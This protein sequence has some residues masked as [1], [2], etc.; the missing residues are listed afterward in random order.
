M[1]DQNK[2]ERLILQHSKH[3]SKAI[4]KTPNKGKQSTLKRNGGPPQKKQHEIT[5]KIGI[6]MIFILFDHYDQQL[7]AVN[8][9]KIARILLHPNAR[10]DKYEIND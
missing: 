8:P 10:K 6:L 4:R 5:Q 2:L 1:E 9:F 3:K 7:L